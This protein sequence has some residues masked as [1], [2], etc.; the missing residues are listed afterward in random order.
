MEKENNNLWTFYNNV[1]INVTFTNVRR[2]RGNLCAAK[3]AMSTSRGNPYN[4]DWESGV[5]AH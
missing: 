4:K 5:T 3:D 1:M 2:M